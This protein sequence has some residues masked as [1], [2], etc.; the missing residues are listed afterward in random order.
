MS[1]SETTPPV[2]QKKDN[3]G[4]LAMLRTLGAISFV[5]G[6]LL[7]VVYQAT[8]SRIQT[9]TEER[10]RSTVLELV[11]GSVIQKEFT[12]FSEASPDVPRTVYAGYDASGTFLGVALEAIDLGGYG[13]E[14]KLLYG[15]IPDEHKIVG[16]KV[17][18]CKETPGLGDKIKTDEHFQKNFESLSVPLDDSRQHLLYP[19]KLVKAGAGGGPGQIEAI[20]GATISSTAVVNGM[21]ESTEVVLPLVH[22][23][24]Q[25]LK[26]Q[27]K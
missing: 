8:F 1:V 11:P 24:L 5:S 21:K 10:I 14:I 22:Q 25:E 12:F 23:H 2:D 4:S 9:N 7:S 13:G 17:L 16:T 3:A 27:G 26:E 6:I 19:L 20:S 18:L 15:Y